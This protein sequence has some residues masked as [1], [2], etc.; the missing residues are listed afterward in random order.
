MKNIEFSDN[1]ELEV[2]CIQPNQIEKIKSKIDWFHNENSFVEM[3]K[4]IIQNYA[5]KIEDILSSD[6][7][8]ISLVSYDGFGKHNNED[9]SNTS[10]P[11]ILPTFFTK[12]ATKNL[13]PTL[14]S[15]SCVH[16]IIE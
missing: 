1:D 12:P 3:P 9:Y 2:F 7:S 14:T 8:T 5:N 11:E 15:R 13:Y 10:N 16:F 4:K 6:S